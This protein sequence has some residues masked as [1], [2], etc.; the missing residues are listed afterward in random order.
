MATQYYNPSLPA[1]SVRASATPIANCFKWV[2]VINP[3]STSLE[4]IG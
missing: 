1:L 4:V 3:M 2:M